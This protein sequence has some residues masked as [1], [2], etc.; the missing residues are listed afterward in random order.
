MK[1]GLPFFAALLLFSSCNS[2]EDKKVASS[3]APSIVADAGIPKPKAPTGKESPRI[4]FVG[5]SHI[6]YY[7]SIPKM[8]GELCAFNKQP[9]QEDE[10]VEMGIS[11]EEIYNADKQKAEELFAKTDADGNYYD[12]VVLQEKT[13]VVIQEVEK[14]KSSVK[15]ML[16]KIKKNS[17]G[18]AVYIYQVMSPENYISSKEDFNGLY[19]DMRTNT[20]SVIAANSNAGMYRVGDAIKDAYDGSN[21]YTYLVN[22]KDKLRFGSNTLHLLNDGGFLASA[23]LYTTIFDKKPAL[24]AMMTFSAG[25]GD[26]DGMKMQQVSEAV[27][28]P[29]ALLE[30]A[31]KNK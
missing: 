9:M 25:T 27:S 20:I 6:E 18:V 8:F 31:L 10:L 28:N 12:Y 30:I 22:G 2:G 11:I 15:M 19:K 13:P 23:L 14:Y 4:L 21:G 16:E 24:P 29:E 3:S 7:T 26:S 5:N 1:K 17:P